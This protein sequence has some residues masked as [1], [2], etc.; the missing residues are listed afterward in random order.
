MK[1]AP[2]TLTCL[3]IIVI[4][5]WYFERRKS[6][7]PSPAAS[8]A[9]A[10]LANSKPLTNPPLHT[11]HSAEPAASLFDQSRMLGLDNA[12]TALAY[13]RG[14][15][16]A[17]TMR[18]LERIITTTNPAIPTKSMLLLALFRAWTENDLPGAKA[19]AE[20]YDTTKWA[21]AQGWARIDPRAVWGWADSLKRSDNFDQSIIAAGFDAGKEDLIADLLAE[22]LQSR[23]PS[24][25]ALNVS[26]LAERWFDKDPTQMWRWL[27]KIETINA[28]AAAYAAGSLAKKLADLPT[29]EFA[30]I[31][32]DRSEVSANVIVPRVVEAWVSGDQLDRITQFV[33]EFPELSG[34]R[35]NLIAGSM[36]KALV[37]EEPDLALKIF[38]NIS[39]PDVRDV[40]ISEGAGRLSG[41]G[42]KR[43][44]TALL[45][46]LEL[47]NETRRV[48][49][50]KKVYQT[51][52]D[53]YPEEAQAAISRDSFPREMRAL[54]EQSRPA[55]LPLLA[56]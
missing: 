15:S 29:K 20:E 7:G 40:F 24:G 9:D 19:A 41:N 56:P 16:S 38:R 5:G 51:F 11:S 13:F 35:Q 48:V 43:S 17:E 54:L 2:T 31:L 49:Y 34:P 55:N 52:V 47:G 21:F 44:E 37:S 39:D 50:L 10:V 3:L 26:Y 18:A 12:E 32:R 4:A 1:V 53:R 30:A 22:R 36:G 8:N 46:A 27:T 28:N 42:P 23:G 25:A 6:R 45:F 14:L 33:A